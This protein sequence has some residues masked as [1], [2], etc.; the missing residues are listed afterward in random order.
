MAT[1][2]QMTGSDIIRTHQ[3]PAYSFSGKANH[4]I[5]IKRE[6][7]GMCQQSKVRTGDYCYF[8]RGVAQFIVSHFLNKKRNERNIS[9]ESKPIK[10]MK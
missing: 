2:A 9:T 10:A 7:S 4:T 3:T 5:Q 8:T 6:R 1:K